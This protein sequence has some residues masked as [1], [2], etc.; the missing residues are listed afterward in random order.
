MKEDLESK[1]GN[2][3]FLQW[4]GKI[5]LVKE[6]ALA[7][8]F[9]GFSLFC[10]SKDGGITQPTNRAPETEIIRSELS[11]SIPDAGPYMGDTVPTVEFI[12]NGWDEDGYIKKF[13]IKSDNEEWFNFPVKK[14]E[15]TNKYTNNPIWWNIFDKYNHTLFVKSVD[16][17]DLEDPTPAEYNW[18]YRGPTSSELPTPPTPPPVIGKP[19]QQATT[20]LE[21]KVTI[22]SSSGLNSYNVSIID[23]LTLQPVS[24]VRL[25]YQEEPNNVAV[26]VAEDLSGLYFS[27]FKVLKPTSLSL[28]GFL[29]D[30]KFKFYKGLSTVYRTSKLEEMNDIGDSPNFEKIN[31]SPVK[32]SELYDWYKQYD[33]FVVNKTILNFALEKAGKYEP[34]AEVALKLN[35]FRD[36][37]L[38]NQDIMIGILND[39]EKIAGGPV[40]DYCADIYSYKNTGILRHVFYV[41]PSEPGEIVL[42]PGSEGVDASVAY[43]KM[44]NKEESSILSRNYGADSLLLLGEIHESDSYGSMDLNGLSLI[45]FD[46]SKIPAN[47]NIS[48]AGLFFYLSSV[49]KGNLGDKVRFQAYRVASAWD[50]NTLNWN[51]KP[52]YDSSP[53]PASEEYGLSF[54]RFSE[55]KLDVLD[56][57][58]NMRAY[59][60][61]GVL[62]TLISSSK[63]DFFYCFSSDYPNSMYRPKLVIK[64]Q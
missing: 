61:N 20:S 58:N 46:L 63:N 55:F 57:V 48:S 53:V 25:T 19:F 56:I 18:V 32:V 51:N 5:P 26:I 39:L 7:G 10:C 38:K 22:N 23:D 21:G 50:E 17:D 31:S 45:K 29:E 15:N 34:M 11:W 2:N 27:D 62:L 6:L 59:G 41:C 1:I 37:V 13:L 4:F 43:L 3:G 24:N 36:D 52:W 54:N 40:N 44:N 30:V 47:A 33:V 35:G 12:F 16:N 8:P 42:Q 9:L 28:A 60:N 64:Y 14:I 49:L